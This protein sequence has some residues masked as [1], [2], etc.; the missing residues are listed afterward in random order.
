MFNTESIALFNV[1]RKKDY[2]SNHIKWNRRLYLENETIEF[3]CIEINQENAKS[4]LI[5][6]IYRPTDS[7]LNL[8]QNCVV[9][10]LSV[11]VNG[12]FPLRRRQY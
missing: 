2:A 7:S 1:L 4:F 3:I 6:C 8:P 5:G 11:S 9:I 12:I 10:L